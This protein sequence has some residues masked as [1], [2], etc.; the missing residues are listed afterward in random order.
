MSDIKDRVFKIVEKHFGVTSDKITDNT[1]FVD[2]LGADSLANVEFVM[3]L[4]DEF[5]IE[6]PEDVADKIRTVGAAID[7]IK[8]QAA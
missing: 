5:G 6:I 3:D 4:E 1:N 2:D 7:Y 8:S